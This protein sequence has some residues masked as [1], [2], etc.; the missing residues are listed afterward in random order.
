MECEGEQY[1]STGDPDAQQKLSRFEL[2]SHNQ[3]M[4]LDN[5]TFLPEGNEQ[6]KSYLFYFVCMGGKKDSI[7]NKIHTISKGSLDSSR[8]AIVLA[9]GLLHREF[10]RPSSSKCLLGD[11]LLNQKSNTKQL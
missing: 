8:N 6:G 2:G 11:N 4:Q 7:Y 10:S 1:C 5:T 3:F 9:G